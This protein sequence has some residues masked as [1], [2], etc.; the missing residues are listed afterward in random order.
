MFANNSCVWQIVADDTQYN[1]DQLALVN[2]D[3]ELLLYA[4][5]NYWFRSPK[6]S[7]LLGP[8]ELKRLKLGQIF[9][10]LSQYS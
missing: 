4:T 9:P 6:L 8:S 7:D 2:L 3:W 10:E 5:E 1:C